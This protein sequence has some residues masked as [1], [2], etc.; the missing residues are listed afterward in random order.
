MI[1]PAT[2]RTNSTLLSNW[3]LSLIF[4]SVMGTMSSGRLSLVEDSTLDMLSMSYADP[5]GAIEM[6][7]GEEGETKLSFVNL[8]VLRVANKNVSYWCGG[9]FCCIRLLLQLLL[10]NI[11]F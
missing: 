2:D 3:P 4:S 8:K 7:G 1:S 6:E 10:I 5:Q 9:N 11:L